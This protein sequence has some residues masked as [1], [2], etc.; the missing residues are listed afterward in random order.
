MNILTINI[1]PEPEFIYVV[2]LVA[3]FL[4]NRSIAASVFF[5]TRTEKE[6]DEDSEDY[7]FHVNKI[8]K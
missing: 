1:S 2:I 4:I 5:A 7:F 8:S 6:T 3:A